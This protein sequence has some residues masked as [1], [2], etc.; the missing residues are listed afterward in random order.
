LIEPF[1]WFATFAMLANDNVLKLKEVSKTKLYT[2]LTFLSLSSAKA[3]F[4][5]RLSEVKQ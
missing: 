1:G 3:E 2:A 5:N 4:N